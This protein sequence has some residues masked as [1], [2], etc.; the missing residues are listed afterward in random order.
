MSKHN[1]RSR[2]QKPVTDGGEETAADIFRRFAHHA[3]VGVGSPYA[4]VAASLVVVLWAVSGPV[5]AFSDTWQLVINTGTTIV[6]F[7]MVFLIQNTQ[8]RDSRAIHLKLDELIHAA[9]GARDRMIDVEELSDEE[10][11]RLQKEFE[12]LSRRRT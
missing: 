12:R 4:F 6:T 7:L 3:S 5:F 11:G 9:H 8:N 2:V 1:G 10:L